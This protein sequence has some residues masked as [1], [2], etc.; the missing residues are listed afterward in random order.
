MRD[1]PGEALAHSWVAGGGGSADEHGCRRTGG[2]QKSVEVPA[3]GHY[4]PAQIRC[5]RVSVLI[6]VA[7]RTVV[8]AVVVIVMLR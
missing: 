2:P 7:G 5:T 3:P 6:R 8:V 4:A 1:E